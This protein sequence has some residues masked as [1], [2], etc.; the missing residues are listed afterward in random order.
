[1]HVPPDNH[2][3]H[4]PAGQDDCVACHR[5]D[6][7]ER[8]TGTGFPTTC[9]SCHTVNT[10][11]GATF[12]HGA[13]TGF[14]LLGAHT[15]LACTSCHVPP[16][17]HLLHTPAGQDDCVACHRADYDGQHAGSGFPTT[18]LT[19]HTV[20]TWSGAT[21]DHDRDYFPIYSGAHREKWSVCTDCHQ[22]S[23][24]FR[25]FTCITCHTRAVTDEKHREVGNYSYV[26]TA[27][28]A[29]HP[30]GRS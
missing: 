29:C 23:T 21:F 8:H 9:L 16:D 2:L 12:D 11:S 17:N 26:S 13:F 18:C 20:N 3:L 10:W 7:D 15:P 1:C 30:Q 27:C 6:Y 4:T 25:Q 5:A 28:L 19:C 22:V 24:D 14:A